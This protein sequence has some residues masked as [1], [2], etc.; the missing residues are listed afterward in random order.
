MLAIE[1]L[2]SSEE[3]ANSFGLDFIN[4][5]DPGAPL[6]SL[7]HCCTDAGVVLPDMTTV[8]ECMN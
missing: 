4:C 5:S 6:G 2:R 1:F 8:G 3:L 7:P